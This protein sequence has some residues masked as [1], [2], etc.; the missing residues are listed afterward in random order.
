MP[1]AVIMIDPMPKMARRPSLSATAVRSR[2]SNTSP[3]SVR[4]RNKPIKLSECGISGSVD[5]PYAMRRTARWMMSSF[6]LA[7]ER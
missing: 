1:E 4:L 3:T 6:T 7:G 5:A 2:L